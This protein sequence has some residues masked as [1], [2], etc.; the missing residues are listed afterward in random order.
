MCVYM[1]NFYD[2]SLNNY[3][4]ML[5]VL[6]VTLDNSPVKHTIDPKRRNEIVEETFSEQKGILLNML[7]SKLKEV[8]DKKKKSND[9]NGGH[10]TNCN[11]PLQ[12][13]DVKL[14]VNGI[15]AI[16]GANVNLKYGTGKGSVSFDA[17]GISNIGKIQMSLALG[18][19]FHIP[20]LNN[21]FI[22][23]RQKNCTIHNVNEP[24]EDIENNNTRRSEN[25]ATHR[26]SASTITANVEGNL[27]ST[28]KAVK[29]KK[30]TVHPVNSNSTAK[31][32]T[33]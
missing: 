15:S 10:N 1:G 8:R 11:G 29:V 30:K 7:E 25:E 23:L 33:L 4:L 5:S 17:D 24:Q 20:G 16:G 19:T 2:G 27:S 13:I 21:L 22:D 14:K 32:K 6:E 3:T 18:E 12:N 9:N 28:A 31:P 26:E